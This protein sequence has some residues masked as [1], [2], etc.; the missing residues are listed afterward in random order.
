MTKTAGSVEP[1]TAAN[2]PAGP[3][4]SGPFKRPPIVSPRGGVKKRLGIP[5]A[6]NTGIRHPQQQQQRGRGTNFGRG[7]AAFQQNRFRYANAV[8]NGNRNGIKCV[9]SSISRLY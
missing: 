6:M 7:R 3:P 2:P 4:D 8:I 5:V 1:G 9:L